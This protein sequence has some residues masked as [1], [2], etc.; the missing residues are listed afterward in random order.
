MD[1]YPSWQRR[2]YGLAIAG[3][4]L[5]IICVTA[6]AVGF[7]VFVIVVHGLANNPY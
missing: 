5:V 6:V 4:V 3:I 7:G 2:R 1:S